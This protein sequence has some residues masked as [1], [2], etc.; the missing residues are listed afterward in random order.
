MPPA[1]SR[2]AEASDTLAVIACGL[3]LWI[4]IEAIADPARVL[5]SCRAYL[6]PVAAR[7]F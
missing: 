4:A 3:A 2:L 5:A 7:L 6:A 1:R